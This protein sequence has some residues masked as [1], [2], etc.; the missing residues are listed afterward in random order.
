MPASAHSAAFHPNGKSVVIGLLGGRWMALELSTQQML[1]S[2][3]DGNEQIECLSFSPDGSSLAVGSR[4]NIIYV[5]SVTEEGQK[6]S[7][8]GRCIVSRIFHEKQFSFYSCQTT[9][10]SIYRMYLSYSYNNGNSCSVQYP[11]RR[12]KT[13]FKFFNNRAIQ[14]L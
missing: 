4:D 14:V 7:R 12:S 5:Y 6:Y 3:I 8:I 10:D 11:L 1:S 13:L 2:H 9:H